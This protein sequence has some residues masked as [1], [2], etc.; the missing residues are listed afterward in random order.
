[1]FGRECNYSSQCLYSTAV[2]ENFWATPQFWKTQHN[3]DFRDDAPI[4]ADVTSTYNTMDSNLKTR[5]KETLVKREVEGQ[6]SSTQ[7]LMR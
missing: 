4:P 1:M 6:H 3:C 7:S 2:L 5:K